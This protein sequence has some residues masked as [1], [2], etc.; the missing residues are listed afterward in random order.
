MNPC[1]EGG[2]RSSIAQR[3]S[4][5]VVVRVGRAGGKAYYK[6]NWKMIPLSIVIRARSSGKALCFNSTS[7][8]C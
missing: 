3:L 5:R 4:Y 1:S 7:I 2:S 6:V 8:E